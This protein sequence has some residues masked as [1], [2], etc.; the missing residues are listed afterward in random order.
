MC[1]RGSCWDASGLLVLATTAVNLGI[2]HRFRLR[3]N[4]AAH[5][6]E[7]A[8]PD[9]MLL[10]QV[11]T[12]FEREEFSSPRLLQLQAQLKQQGMPPSRAIAKLNRLV[13]YLEMRTTFSCASSTQ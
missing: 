8:G 12:A 4:E 5:A 9:L 7:E 6:A 13:D 10:S 3:L 1:S 11:L 2:S